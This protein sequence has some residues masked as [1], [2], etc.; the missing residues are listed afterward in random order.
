MLVLL[1]QAV[2]AA[3]FGGYAGGA[4]F[5]PGGVE[6]AGQARYERVGLLPCDD[7]RRG[8][9]DGTAEKGPCQDA[10][11]AHVGDHLLD[12]AGPRL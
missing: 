4:L 10:L 1:L 7:E 8:E 12:E 11:R 3:S 9:V 2:V 6:G 5:F